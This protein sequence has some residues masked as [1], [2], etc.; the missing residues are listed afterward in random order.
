[1]SP[2]RHRRLALAALL[3]AGVTALLAHEGHAPLPTSG[4]QVDTDRGTLALA[5]RARDAVDVRTAEVEARPVAERVPAYA[6][7]IAPWRN[8]GYAAARL[9]G[10]VVR[11]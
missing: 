3:T 4:V 7:L 1:M 10:R 8:H 6:A 9:P 5:A 2:R 11:L